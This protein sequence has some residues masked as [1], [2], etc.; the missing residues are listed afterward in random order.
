MTLLPVLLIIF[1]GALGQSAFG[2]GGGLIA[3]PL[4]S[5]IIGVRDS[6]TLALV[7]QLATGFLLLKLRKDLRWDILKPM[8]APL[9]VGT[10]LGTYLLSLASEA[11]LRVFLAGFIFIYLIKTQFFDDSRSPF[12]RNRWFGSL[13]GGTA[14]L[15]QGLIGSGGPPMLIY[16]REI[17]SEPASVRAGLLLLLLITNS[18]R[19]IMS[20]ST[21]L[22]S[23]FVLNVS[24]AAIPCLLLAMF[25]GE[26]VF[27]RF[28][29]NG[30]K[31]AISIL[32]VI[33]MLSLLYKTL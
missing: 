8:I 13:A 16:L 12:L 19:L 2:F 15:I 26:K 28:S 18:L 7:L 9:L 21:G 27:R 10:A 31:S 5:L 17:I 24:L 23:S 20:L 33:S 25:L 6:V 32:L 29:E 30:Y 3:I 1:L 11:F 14:G 4:L 22:F